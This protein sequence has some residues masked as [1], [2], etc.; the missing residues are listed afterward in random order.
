MKN[1]I[2][3]NIAD[4]R[5]ELGLTQEELATRMG[6]KSKSTINKIE[7]GIN[8]IPQ[9]KIV[10]FAEA[11]H[12]S[13]SVLMGWEKELVKNDTTVLLTVRL[14]TDDEFLSVVEELDKLD[15]VQLASVK[16]IVQTLLRK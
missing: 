8:D 5:K 10:K 3:K 13:P 12:T 4:R 1:G 2:G 9:T 6:Y 16:Q 7:L 14:R 15:A 11:L